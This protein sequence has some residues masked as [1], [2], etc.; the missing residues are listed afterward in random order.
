MNFDS[1]SV[2]AKTDLAQIVKI[3]SDSIYVKVV[4]DGCKNCA[5][6][7]VCK[8]EDK[9]KKFNVTNPEEYNVGDFVEIIIKSGSRIFSAFMIFI[10]P[11]IFMI[12]FYFAASYLFHLNENLSAIL[13]ILGLLIGGIILKLSDKKLGDKITYEIKKRSFTNENSS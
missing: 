3:E 9:V 12:G 2:D 10:F 7:G 5:L 4:A 13:S 1:K 6:S 11:L 8:L